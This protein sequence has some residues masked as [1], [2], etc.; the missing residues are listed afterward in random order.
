MS[1]TKAPVGGATTTGPKSLEDELRAV[2]AGLTRERKPETFELPG[3]GRRLQVEYRVLSSDEQDEVAERVAEQSKDGQV[4]TPFFTALVDNLIKACVCFKTETD[5]AVIRLRRDDDPED[6]AVIR[7]GDKRLAAMFKIDGPDG[8]DPSARQIMCQLLGDD[9][10][11]MEHGQAVMLWM[12]ES[13]REVQTD[14]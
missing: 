3:F 14:F 11:V 12:K 4:D 5:G 2:H 1:E 7:W 9:R 13:L 8:K 6:A 10:L